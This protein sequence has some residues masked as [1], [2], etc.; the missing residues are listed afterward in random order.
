MLEQGKPALPPMP[1]RA[2]LALLLLLPAATF[3]QGAKL[4]GP[5]ADAD[6]PPTAHLR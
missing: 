2:A 5:R 1:I 4:E 3:A 6:V